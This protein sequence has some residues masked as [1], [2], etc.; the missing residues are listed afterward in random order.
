MPRQRAP[1]AQARPK[2]HTRRPTP[3]VWS[4]GRVGRRAGQDPTTGLGELNQERLRRRPPLWPP[5]RCGAPEPP[6]CP[7]PIPHHPHRRLQSP[8]SRPTP[9]TSTCSPFLFLPPH[10]HPPDP[11][12]TL[13]RS[14]PCAPPQL[15]PQSTADLHPHPDPRHLHM[16]PPAAPTSPLST[17][18]WRVIRA[19]LDEAAAAPRLSAHHGGESQPRGCQDAPQRRIGAAAPWCCRS[20]AGRGVGPV[21]RL[22]DALRLPH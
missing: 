9:P 11:P 4:P 20:S 10:A 2:G 16:C 7:P 12:P 5:Q 18:P 21:W 22:R 15:A 8:L 3:L 13:A 14:P 17:L 1:G 6:V 19:G